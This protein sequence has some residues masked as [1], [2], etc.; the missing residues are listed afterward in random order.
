MAVPMLTLVI[1]DHLGDL[2]SFL[3]A[4]MITFVAGLAL[5]IPGRPSRCICA[6]GTCTC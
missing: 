6:P 1:Y 3:W 4:S 5:V 2:P